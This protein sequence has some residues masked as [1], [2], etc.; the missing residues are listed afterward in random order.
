MPPDQGRGVLGIE[1]ELNRLMEH[2]I[3]AEKLFEI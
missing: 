1:I 3:G 2:P